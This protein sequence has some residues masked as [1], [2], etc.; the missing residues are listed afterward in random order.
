M[1]VI[2]ILQML[3]LPRELYMWIPTSS[4]HS[5]GHMQL[6]R[7]KF[8]RIHGRGAISLLEFLQQF[9]GADSVEGLDGRDTGCNDSEVEL[10]RRPE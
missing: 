5:S 8:I 2:P 6:H 4:H 9:L 1:I 7:R 3:T 10:D